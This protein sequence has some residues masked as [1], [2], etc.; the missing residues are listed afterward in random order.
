MNEVSAVA[1]FRDTL[2]WLWQHYGDLR[3]FVE[4]DIEWTLQ[5]RL[6]ETIEDQRL[7]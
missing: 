2:S 3:F 5:T 4:R 1:L 6:L 7:P